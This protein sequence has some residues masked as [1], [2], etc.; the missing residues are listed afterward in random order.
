MMF[1]TVLNALRQHLYFNLIN[2]ALSLPGAMAYPGNGQIVWETY[3][4]ARHLLVYGE[5]RFYRYS[6]TY[7]GGWKALEID[8]FCYLGEMKL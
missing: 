4:C 1:I 8:W 3:G 2:W 7:V 5:P 6:P